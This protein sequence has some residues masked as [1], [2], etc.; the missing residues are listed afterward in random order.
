MSESS[1]QEDLMDG[2][3][4]IIPASVSIESRSSDY[5]EVNPFSEL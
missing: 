5:N 2:S 4:A 3:L 1:R